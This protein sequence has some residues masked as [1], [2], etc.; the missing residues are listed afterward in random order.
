M[1][2][3]SKF[4]VYSE[5]ERSKKEV[6]DRYY[7]LLNSYNSYTVKKNLFDKSDR[8]ALSN[9]QNNFRQ[10]CLILIPYEKENI[11]SEYFD[12]KQYDDVVWLEEQT[13]KLLGFNVICQL[14]SIGSENYNINPVIIYARHN[15]EDEEFV[16]LKKID[17][18]ID[19][20]GV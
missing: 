5:Y 20:K 10:L 14:T 18:F 4:I 3:E 16:D 7:A 2:E 1:V 9:W 13:K 11:K 17:E 12:M 19:N 8:T 6:M 15:Y